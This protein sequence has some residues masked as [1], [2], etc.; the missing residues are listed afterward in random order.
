M[1][2]LLKKYGYDLPVTKS[3]LYQEILTHK[4]L[5]KAEGFD[6]HVKSIS[7]LI[8]YEIILHGIEN[9]NRIDNLYYAFYHETQDVLKYLNYEEKQ[10]IFNGELETVLA[11]M[12]HFNE[13]YIPYLEPFINERYCHNYMMLILKQHQLYIRQYPRTVD[14]PFALYG[15][16]PM[17]SSFSSCQA[18]GQ[19]DEYYYFYLD[20]FKRIVI[21]SKNEYELYDEIYLCD[22]YNKDAV[23][24]D[25]VYHLI[26]L[27]C[28][29]KAAFFEELFNVGYI[30]EKTYKKI[31]KKLK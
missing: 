12:K 9:K 29:N 21:F 10:K 28:Q 13:I 6:F 15:Y 4:D 23:K 7:D 8:K 26:E 24:I 20:E 1:L 18:L 22:K 27:F 31:K 25:E 14:Q 16:K 5:F 19:D 30:K 11:N 2:K 17:I 3:K